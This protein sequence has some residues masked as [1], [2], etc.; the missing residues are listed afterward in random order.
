MYIRCPCFASFSCTKSGQP[1]QASIENDT[2]K[3]DMWAEH[4]A[5]TAHAHAHRQRTHTY[6][7]DCGSHIDKRTDIAPTWID[8][9]KHRHADTHPQ[10]HGNTKTHAATMLRHL[11]L[12]CRVMPIFR[13]SLQPSPRTHERKHT[14][15]DTD[16]APTCT[17]DSPCVPRGSLWHLTCTISSHQSMS[18]PRLFLIHINT[19]K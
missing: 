13:I 9:R 4:R 2:R 5:P 18:S 1:R 15:N 11:L 19:S 12:F 8:T 14:H 3:H 16:G 17:D 6:R 7:H 10:R